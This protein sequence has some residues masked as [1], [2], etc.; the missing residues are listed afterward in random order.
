MTKNLEDKEILDQINDFLQDQES[1]D[2]MSLIFKLLGDPTR[3]K[4]IYVLSKTPMRVT[5]IANILDMSQSLI[6][7]QLA[8]LRQAKL[9]K[10]KR[11]SRNAIYS[12]D[13]AHVLSIFDQAHEHAK[14]ERHRN[15]WQLY[16][17]V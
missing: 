4:I 3:L 15:D 7:H 13:D 12:L 6:S 9:I 16:Y 11:V 8:E 10:V 17:R 14:H 2:Y 5:D 1:S